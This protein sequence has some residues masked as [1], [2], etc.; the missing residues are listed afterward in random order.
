ML[1]NEGLELISCTDS[2]SLLEEVVQHRPEALICGLKPDAQQ[3]FSL[4]RLVKRAAP[5][6]PLVLI[7]SEG[8]LH[9][10][11]LAQDLRP[12]Y[13]AVRPVEVSELRDAVRA[14][15]SRPASPGSEPTHGGA[16]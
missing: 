11:R 12:I 4:L 5:K 14:A 8:S 7:A 9:A 1:G 10:Q 6:L 15:L 2:E 13:Y 16:R 3:D